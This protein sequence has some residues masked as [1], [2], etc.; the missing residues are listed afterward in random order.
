MA[1]VEKSVQGLQRGTRLVVIGDSTLWNNQLLYSAGNDDLAAF[2]ANW[3]VSQ[4]I[5]LSDIPRR[6]IHTYQLTMT[7]SHLR[8]VQLIL[9]AGMPGAVLLVG[10]LIWWRRRH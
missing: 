6:A 1:V 4:N 7:R 9:M 3:L 8:S 5:L 10:V 2:A